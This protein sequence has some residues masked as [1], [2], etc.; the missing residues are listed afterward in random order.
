MSDT[1]KT[2]PA[3]SQFES[4]LGDLGETLAK[5]TPAAAAEGE[6]EKEGAA[7]EGEG[8]DADDAQIAAAAAEGEGEKE[9]VA[10]SFKIVLDDGTEVDAIDGGE[11]VKSLMARIENSE[12]AFGAFAT[13][14]TNALVGANDL[15][16]S[17]QTQV[18]ALADSGRGRKAVLTISERPAATAETLAKSE[19]PTGMQPEEFLTKAM[20][21]QAAGLLR[22]V[23]VSAAE[24]AI[25]AGQQPDP[26]IV[27]IVLDHA[28]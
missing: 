16:K 15:V 17:L 24:I 28:K 6:G 2:A 11:L 22:A 26:A 25:G 14:M 19:A 20:S 7:A 10:K 8:A 13:T 5:S 23:D 1:N 9:T 12:T 3:K 18:A 27:R 21:A 4:L